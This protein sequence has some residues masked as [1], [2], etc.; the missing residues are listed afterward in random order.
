MTQFAKILLTKFHSSEFVNKKSKSKVSAVKALTGFQKYLNNLKDNVINKE[1]TDEYLISC[2]FHN[3][4]TAKSNEFNSYA[5]AQFYIGTLFFNKIVDRINK[6]EGSLSYYS[7]KK[8]NIPIRNFIFD[9][10]YFVEY[11][12][13]KKN[14]NFQLFEG[15][16]VK[17]N[18]SFEIYRTLHNL[19]WLPV[20]GAKIIDYKSTFNTSVFLIRQALEVRFKRVFGILDIYNKRQERPRL[21]A[22]F[23]IN[24]IKNHLEC[25]ELPDLNLTFISKIYKWTNYSIHNAI[26]PKIWEIMYATNILDKWFQ[27]DKIIQNGKL[28]SFNVYGNIKIKEFNKVFEMLIGEINTKVDNEIYC[29][30]LGIIES[31]CI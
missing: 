2:I 28:K 26:N 20:V 8:Y 11:F 9:F 7:I 25:F 29:I 3:K 15:F 17:V 6:N 10:K 19:M 13:R 23:Y 4:V 18:S 1:Y 24:F 30:Q 5:K 16:D 27:G 12:E 14:P 31:K 22:D 21:K